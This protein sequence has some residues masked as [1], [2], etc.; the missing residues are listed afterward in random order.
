MCLNT[1]LKNPA[2]KFKA[3]TYLLICYVDYISEDRKQDIFNTQ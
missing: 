1:N 2:Q 3:T